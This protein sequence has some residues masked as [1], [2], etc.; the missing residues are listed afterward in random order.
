[1]TIVH[2]VEQNT[3]EWLQLRLGIPTAS[4]FSRILTPKNLTPSASRVK[5]MHELLAEWSL[6]EPVTDESVGGFRGRGHELEGLARRHYS[7]VHS[8]DGEVRS[9]G[10]VTRDDGM[11]GASPDALVGDN[12]LLEIKCPSAANHVAN[13]LNGAGGL[14]ADYRMQVQG[15]IMVTE[16]EWCD[17]LSYNPDVTPVEVVTRCYP[18]PD[19]QIALRNALD[20][21]IGE[22]LAA[23]DR[24]V[25]LGGIGS[26]ASGGTA[27][28][29]AGSR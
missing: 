19:V 24:M 13:V 6:G 27:R 12:G 14:A 25:K 21:F 28:P 26:C 22:L 18:E 9:V 20:Q 3:P 7:F 8:G 5:Y 10:F 2:D 15:E 17:I 11:V 4:Q 1:M 29:R 23:R 16:R